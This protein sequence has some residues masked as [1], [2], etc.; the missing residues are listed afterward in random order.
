MAMKHCVCRLTWTGIQGRMK[1]RIENVTFLD[2]CICF[3]CKILLLREQFWPLMG[4][5]QGSASTDSSPQQSVSFYAE[6]T[7]WNVCRHNN[8]LSSIRTD[9]WCGKLVFSD[10]FYR[11]PI[12]HRRTPGQDGALH[13]LQLLHAPVYLQGAGRLTATDTG[14]NLW[15]YLLAIAVWHTRD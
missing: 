10:T 14:G 1:I 11:S 7:Q 6:I 13:L 8:G 2:T 9:Q 3:G 4:F 15:V 5:G 12:L